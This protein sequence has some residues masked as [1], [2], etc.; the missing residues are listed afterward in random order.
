MNIHDNNRPSPRHKLNV[1]SLHKVREFLAPV[2]QYPPLS[3]QSHDAWGA[4]KGIEH[5]RDTTIARFV[6]VTDCLVAGTGH[7]Q[8]PKGLV[9]EEAEVR[10][11]LGGDVDMTGPC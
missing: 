3:P 11:A 8:I 2:L 10:A 6:D 7:V 9:V 1:I 4:F 5:D